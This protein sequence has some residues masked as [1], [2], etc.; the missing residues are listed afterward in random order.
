MNPEDAADLMDQERTRNRFKQRAAITI[1][2][3]AMLL[4][5]T[6]LGGANAGKEALNNN[7]L[8]SN[9][10][11]FFQ[12]KNSRQTSYDLA[13]AEFELAWAADPA[14]SAEA[15]AALKQKA[16]ADRKTIDRYESE[17]STN[18]GK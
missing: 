6:S 4:A 7:V 9:Y 2:I 3:M 12:A 8:A 18:E 14:M 17:P 16:E 11:N 1:A 13:L 15:K 10:F 5:I